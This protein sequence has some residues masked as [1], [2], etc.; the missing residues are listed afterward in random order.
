MRPFEHGQ[1]PG[2]VAPAAAASD[3]SAGTASA[4]A[5]RP[6]AAVLTPQGESAT[7]ARAAQSR[8]AGGHEDSS[9]DEASCSAFSASRAE[10]ALNGY[11]LQHA[12]WDGHLMTLWNLS[13]D[14]ASLHGVARF[15]QR[16]AR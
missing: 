10:L 9:S 2:M 5:N 6:P 11:R 13:P 16:A 3:Q 12:R 1:R 7:A 15:L 14:K 8:A 4:E